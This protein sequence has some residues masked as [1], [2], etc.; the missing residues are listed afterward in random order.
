MGSEILRTT[1]KALLFLCLTPLLLVACSERPDEQEARD[2]RTASPA[3]GGEETTEESA[4]QIAQSGEL[5]PGRYS[6]AQTFEPPFSLEVGRGWRVL[7]DSG[8]HSL[9]L[10]YIA[11]EGAVAEGKALRFNAVREVFEPTG[12]ESGEPLF[13]TRPVPE[14]LASWLRRNPYLEAGDPRPAEVGGASGE[15][16]DARVEVP[17]SYRDEHG[18]GCPLPCVPLFRL[19]DGSVSHVTERGMDRFVVLED[20]QGEKVAVI[21]SAPTGSFEQFSDQ[22][23]EVLDSVEWQE[24]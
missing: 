21:L 1:L 19:G 22:A 3:R 23:Q 5:A 4:R 20:V 8:P 24:H 9:R 7:P 14:D 13:E 18:G 11:S 6:T 16:F 2:E 10:G 12:E 17:E 15:S